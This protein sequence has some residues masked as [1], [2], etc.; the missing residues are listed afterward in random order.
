[1]FSTNLKVPTTVRHIL[2]VTLLDITVSAWLNRMNDGD[3]LVKA[4]PVV[5][6][7]NADGAVLVAKLLH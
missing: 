1:M 5:L 2:V 4:S 3:P 6:V 7:L